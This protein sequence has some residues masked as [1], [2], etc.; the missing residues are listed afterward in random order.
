MS[1]KKYEDFGKRIAKK[2]TDF[3]K[4]KDKDIHISFSF[5]GNTKN[6]DIDTDDF[7]GI[8]FFCGGSKGKIPR[9]RGIIKKILTTVPK[10]YG[11]KQRR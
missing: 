8:S 7:E 2:F 3:G 4:K 9:R 5:G 11:V 10:R 1:D 6:I